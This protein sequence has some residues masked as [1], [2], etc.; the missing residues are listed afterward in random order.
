MRDALDWG[1]LCCV[2]LDTGLTPEAADLLRRVRPSGVIVFRRDAPDAAALRALS[3]AVWEVLEPEGIRPLIAA[4]EEGGFVT[5]LGAPFAAV[6]APLAVARGG[7]VEEAESVGAL[8]GRRLA[9]CGVSVD[10]APSLDVNSEPANP[11]IGSRAYGETAAAVSAYGLATARGLSAAG[12]AWCA[13]H[14]PGH[15]ATHLDSHIASPRVSRDRASLEAVDLSPFRAALAAQA[16][17]VMTAHVVFDALDRGMPATFSPQ[18]VRGLLRETLG[19]DGVIVTDDLDMAGATALGAP[20][21]IAARALHAGCDWLLFAKRG[22]DAEA[23]VR[24]VIAALE[25]GRLD[26]ARLA[27]S[28]ARIRALRERFARRPSET[29]EAAVARE[30]AHAPLLQRLATQALRWSGPAFRPRRGEI[31]VAEATDDAA[32]ALAPLLRD[33]GCDARSVRPDEA[34]EFLGPSIGALVV[35]AAER[36]EVS[37]AACD[38]LA[39][40]FTAG[41]PTVLVSLRTPYLGDAFTDLTAVL[42]SCDDGPFGRAAVAHAL[43]DCCAD[44]TTR[45]PR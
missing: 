7:S 19:Y 40:A 32:L 45:R 5:Q 44:A 36:A 42:A 27:E 29:L 16:P 39:D 3:E 10:F 25:A 24:G 17:L 2:G 1:E 26:E 15:G 34:P 18:I 12:V 38:A 28:L 20:G 30:D 21:D 6:P 31:L 35:T 13:K 8:L 33:A 11:V 14:F 22:A 4:D 23:G 37:E 41:V 9:A 43:A